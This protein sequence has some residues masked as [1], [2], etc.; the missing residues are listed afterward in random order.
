MKKDRDRTP[1]RS[2]LRAVRIILTEIIFMAV[3]VCVSIMPM[4]YRLIVPII[5]GTRSIL[6]K[7][8]VYFKENPLPQDEIKYSAAEPKKEIKRDARK[9][10]KTA[11]KKGNKKAA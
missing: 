8:R 3:S 10:G 7:A 11:G 1:R 5:I 9:T 4:P 2:K 6:L